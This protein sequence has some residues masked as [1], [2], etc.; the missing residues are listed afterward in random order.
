V[1]HHVGDA[2]EVELR[3]LVGE[4]DAP[5]ADGAGPLEGEDPLVAQIDLEHAAVVLRAAGDDG[6]NRAGVVTEPAVIAGVL[7][8]VLVT[9]QRRD[10]DAA[11]QERQPSVDAGV[12]PV[13]HGMDIAT[14]LIR[15]MYWP[16]LSM[17]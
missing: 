6:L 16:G 1:Q 8:R 10:A 3:D 13:T 11:A 2:L 12:G 5:G 17:S 9:G 14:D 4:L 15:R 7:P